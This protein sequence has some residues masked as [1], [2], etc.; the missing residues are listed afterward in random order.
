MSAFLDSSAILR[1]L[2][3]DDPVKAESVYNLLKR[4]SGLLVTPVTVA[5]VAWVLEGPNIGL[6]RATACAALQG[7]F[8]EKNVEVHDL[9]RVRVAQAIL[10]CQSRSVSFEDAFIWAQA[11]DLG[12]TIYTYDRKFPSTD[13]QLLEP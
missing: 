9:S 12:A 3:N 7:F 11:A 8:Q 6:P 4:S 5:E 10:Y 13:V 2:L 1:Y